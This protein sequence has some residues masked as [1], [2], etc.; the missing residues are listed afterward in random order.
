MMTWPGALEHQGLLMIANRLVD[1]V[2]DLRSRLQHVNDIEHAQHGDFADRARNLAEYLRAAVLVASSDAYAPAFALVRTALEH[3]LVDHLVFSGQRYVRIVVGVDGPTWTQWQ[4]QRAAGER[5][6]DILDWV[7][8]KDTVEITYE[9]LRSAPD[10]GGQSYVISPHYFLLRQ[11]QPYL[12]PPSAQA[13]FDD[14]IGEPERDRQFARENDLIYRTYLSWSSIKKNLTSNGFAD[15]A[16]IRRL[17]VHYRFLSAFVHPLADVTDVAYGRNNFNIPS[18]DHYSSELVLLYVIA[19]A[20]EEL[21]HFREMTQ[22]HPNIE[23]ADWQ[24]TEELCESAWHKTS[25]LWFPGQTPHLYDRMQ[26]ANRRAFRMLQQGTF[27]GRRLI[28]PMSIPDKEMRYYRD[29]MHRLVALHSG[30]QEIMTGFSFI[31]PWPRRDAQLG[32]RL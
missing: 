17:E 30:F 31:S 4:R 7:R 9:G 23:I 18:Y 2:R 27:E 16:A 12:G 21:R 8:K 25:Y 32:T 26:E 1:E 20:V 13:E 5:F 10:E 14:G 15:D 19:I 29:P 28:D 24:S 6:T 11:Y 3:M 22:R